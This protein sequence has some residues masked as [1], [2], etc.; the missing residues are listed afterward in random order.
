MELERLLDIHS[1]EHD[2]IPFSK[3]TLIWNFLPFVDHLVQGK[4]MHFYSAF[5]PQ[6]KYRS[7]RVVSDVYIGGL[8]VSRLLTCV[9]EQ[10]VDRLSA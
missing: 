2:K 3:P 4:S 10:E 9:R 1:R 5:R 8:A 6:K 7:L